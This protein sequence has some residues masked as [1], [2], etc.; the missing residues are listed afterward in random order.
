MKNAY[1]DL[2]ASGYA[3]SVEVYEQHQLVGGLYGVNLGKTFFGESMFHKKKDASKVALFHLVERLKKWKFLFID[4]QIE[5][6]HLKSF[7]ATNIAR[8]D[9]IEQL[10]DALHASTRKG[11]W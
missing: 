3:H 9:F 10:R 1:I 4:A 6:A 11:K 8:S 7:G 2:H 5:T